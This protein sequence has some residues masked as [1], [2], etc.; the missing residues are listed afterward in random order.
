MSIWF[1]AQ[2]ESTGFSRYVLRVYN[3]KDAAARALVERIRRDPKFP[4]HIH[5]RETFDCVLRCRDWPWAER[6]A[7]GDVW[8]RYQ[9][10]ARNQ[11][12]LAA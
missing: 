7:A 12:K 4:R 6:R 11:Q 1:S 10:W 5:T 9:A 8:A 2:E 3:P